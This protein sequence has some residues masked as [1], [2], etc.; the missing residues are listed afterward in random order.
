MAIIINEEAELSAS[1]IERK[2]IRN[3][4]SNIWKGWHKVCDIN[5]ENTVI[6]N[7]NRYKINTNRS[8]N[9]INTALASP[10]RDFA[11]EWMNEMKKWKRGK[12][13]S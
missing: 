12:F 2:S 3:A 1:Y 6:I 7:R 11:L 8:I 13:E 10:P 5:N 9:R 4:S